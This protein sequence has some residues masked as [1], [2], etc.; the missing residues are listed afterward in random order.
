MEYLSRYWLSFDLWASWSDFGCYT[1]AGILGCEFDGVL[2]TTN[3]LEPF[4]GL[5]KRKHFRRWQRGGQGLRVDVLIKIL[6]AVFEQR[7]M[8]HAER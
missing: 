7:R 4:N 5:L 6:P 8:Q 2:P 1:A 3:D